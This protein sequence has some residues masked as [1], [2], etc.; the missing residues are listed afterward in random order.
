[1]HGT[2]FELD[3]KSEQILALSLKKNV[4]HSLI[5]LFFNLLLDSWGVHFLT[6]N[7]WF[8]LKLKAGHMLLLSQVKLSHRVVWR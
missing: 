2:E 5:S 8:H 6:A 3:C 7:E 4:C 1:M